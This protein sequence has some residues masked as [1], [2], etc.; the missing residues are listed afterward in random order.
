MNREKQAFYILMEVGE[1]DFNSLLRNRQSGDEA[2]S[3]DVTFVRYYWKEMLECVRAIHAQAVV[4]S[5][6]KPANFV[7]VGGRLKLIDFGIANAIQTDMTVNVHRE[8]MAGTINYMSPESLMDS[9]QYALT[10]MHNGHFNNP[11]RGAPRIVKVGKPSDVW[12]LGCILYQMV[13]GMPPFGKIAEPQSR[14]RAIVDWSYRIDI[15]A[16]TDDGSRVPDALMQT[17]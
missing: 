13:Y 10:L 15:P 17:M 4:H 14:I 11:G 2:P 6:L 1:L 7:L 12:S 8:T 5:D 16:T 9:N 3:F